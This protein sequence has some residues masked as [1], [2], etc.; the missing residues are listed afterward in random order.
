MQKREL[1]DLPGK[2]DTLESRQK[3]LYET[4]SDPLFYKKDK[5]EIARMKANL[6]LLENEIETTYLRWEELENIA[7]C[8]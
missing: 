3:E 1:D 2:L 4:M 7:D 5:V 8:E 6:D